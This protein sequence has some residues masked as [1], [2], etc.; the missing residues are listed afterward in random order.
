MLTVAMSDGQ[1]EP[2]EQKEL[3]Q[4]AQRLGLRIEDYV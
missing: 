2:E 3:T 1:I 4:V